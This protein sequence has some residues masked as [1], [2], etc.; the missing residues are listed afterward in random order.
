MTRELRLP[1]KP[2][3]LE[4]ARSD[5]GVTHD[6][7]RNRSAKRY[8]SL[9]WQGIHQR[10]APAAGPIILTLVFEFERPAAHYVGR[11]KGG[12]LR[13]DAPRRWHTIKPDGDN[14]VKLI[15]DALNGVAWRDDAEVARLVV[16]KV[17]TT[18]EPCTLIGVGEL[19]GRGAGSG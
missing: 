3:P 4:R 16:S 10:A 7:A 6:T 13:D 19:E 12:E 17:W 1:G 9:C 15:K 18:G 14:L 8:V 5:R 11:R 2:V